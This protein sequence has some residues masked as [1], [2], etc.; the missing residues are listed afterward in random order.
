MSLRA[1][2]LVIAIVLFVLASFVPSPPAPP[3]VNLQALGLA[4]F[5]A[6]FLVG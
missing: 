6:A 2:F 3:R 4:F 1:V 5:A